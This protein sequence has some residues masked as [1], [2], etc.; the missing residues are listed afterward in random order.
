MVPQIQ[1]HFQTVSKETNLDCI[2]NLD[3][4]R[5]AFEKYWPIN[6]F[7]SGLNT[8]TSHGAYLHKYSARELAK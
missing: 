7:V 5:P 8:K 2:L 6:Y 4:N 3:A 1:F